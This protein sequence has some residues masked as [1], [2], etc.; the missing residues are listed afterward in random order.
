MDI[1]SQDILKLLIS[2]ILGGLIGAERE[3]HD[4]SA[5]FRTI[6]FIC[7]GATLFTIFSTKIGGDNDPR[8]ASNIVSGVG[9]LG[10]GVILRA[11][12]RIVGLTTASMIWLSAA[13]GMGV[14]AGQFLFVSAA[15]AIILVVLWLFPAFEEWIDKKRESRVYEITCGVG[16]GKFDR[17][18]K[19]EEI[20]Y[21]SKLKVKR[22]KQCKTKEQEIV[23]T[24][25]TSGNPQLHEQLIKELIQNKNVKAFSY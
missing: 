13:I 17:F 15:V 19:I 8:I 23:C 20:F 22:S 18:E 5:G 24:F 6:I 10:A 12:G 4:K 3:Y 16:D 14:G 21:S 25:F 11:S 1:T 9:F 2:V 7:V